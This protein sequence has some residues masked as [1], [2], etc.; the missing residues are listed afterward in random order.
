[1]A[2]LPCTR[3]K[4]CRR[5]RR[6]LPGGLD[7]YLFVIVHGFGFVRDCV[8]ALAGSAEPFY[9]DFPN[10]NA[11]VCGGVGGSIGEGR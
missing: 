6:A 11:D 3:A 8:A 5:C 1:M 9:S 7:F 10:G 4:T 2:P